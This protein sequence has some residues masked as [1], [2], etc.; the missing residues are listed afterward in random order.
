MDEIIDKLNLMTAERKLF[1]LK[2]LPRHLCEANQFDRL[3]KILTNY[4]FVKSKVSKKMI[5]SLIDDYQSAIFNT[6]ENSD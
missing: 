6:L 4:F 1:I 3:R 2:E 5:Y